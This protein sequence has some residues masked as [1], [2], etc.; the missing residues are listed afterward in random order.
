[1]LAPY[2][3]RNQPLQL[4]RLSRLIEEGSRSDL[5]MMLRAFDPLFEDLE[6]IT[7]RSS[8]SPAISVRRAGSVVPAS[9][10]GDGFRRALTIALAITEARA[11]LLLIDEIETALHV[12]VLSNLFGW[13]IHACEI[14]NVQLFATTH[15]LEAVT[16]MLA[17]VPEHSHQLLAAYHLG[18]D[19]GKSVPPK[20]YSIEMMKRLVQD[21]GLDIR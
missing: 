16:G 11:G 19:S 21:R 17:A 15:S 4:R 9:V 6:I 18:C 13:L 20:R 12:S 5:L 3:H 1:M 2:S 14:F 8:G 7:D 10:M